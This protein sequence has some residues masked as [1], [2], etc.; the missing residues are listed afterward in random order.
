MRKAEHLQE[1]YY[2][3]TAASYDGSHVQPGDEH[4]KALHFISALVHELELESVLD[5]GA[6]TGR[7]VEYLVNHHPHVDV[8]GVEPVQAL[9]DQAVR[10][11]GLSPELFVEARGE[12][13]PFPDAS[14][15]A[16]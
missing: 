7:G 11:R 1:R 9:V 14:F 12:A 3:A 4:Y 5:V 10:S 16:V 15:D 2:A 13:L 8:K 6:G